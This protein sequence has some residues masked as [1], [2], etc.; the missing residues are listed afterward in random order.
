M[1]ISPEKWREASIHG[2]KLAQ[3]IIERSGQ[4]VDTG[5]VTDP[6]PLLRDA[7]IKHSNDRMRTYMRDV[8][9]V[10]VRLRRSYAEV[11]D[12]ILS[13]TRCKERL[14]KALEY[15]QKD[16]AL[17]QESRDIRASR[18]NREKVRKYFSFVN[19]NDI[20]CFPLGSRWCR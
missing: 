5:K 12:E 7:C 17:N 6:L 18:P 1:E 20:N 14:E 15:K 11:N 2:I 10:V 4:T 16:L 13:A 9:G 19:H 3:T 8:R